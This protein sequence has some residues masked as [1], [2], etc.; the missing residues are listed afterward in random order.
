MNNPCPVCG[1][2][3]IFG[4]WSHVLDCY[5][6]WLKAHPQYV[7]TVLVPQGLTMHTVPLSVLQRIARDGDS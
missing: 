3:I 6:L 1:A 5:Q 4:R 7:K 2:R